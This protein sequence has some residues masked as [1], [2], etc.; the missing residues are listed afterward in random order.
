MIRAIK[1]RQIDFL[2][3]VY[4]F[5]KNYE[6]NMDYEGDEQHEGDHVDD[7][8]NQDIVSPKEK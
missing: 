4:A 1:T 8:T 2:Y 7:A 3:S 5:N 6:L